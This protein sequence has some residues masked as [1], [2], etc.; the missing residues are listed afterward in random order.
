MASPL[1][2]QVAVVTGGGS[3]IGRV[4]AVTLARAGAMVAVVGRN[5]ERLEQ[6]LAW[7]QDATG[8]S[9]DCC[10][11]LPLDVRSESDMGQMAERVLGRFGHIDILI[12]CAGISGPPASGLKTVA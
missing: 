6:T 1:E 5:A 9:S 11:A 8:Q 4:T 7:I 12:T 10:L 2:N 3:G